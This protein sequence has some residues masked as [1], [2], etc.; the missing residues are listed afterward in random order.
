MI[1]IMFEDLYNMTYHFSDNSNC[2]H[3]LVSMRI[4][5]CL[6]IIGTYLVNLWIHFIKALSYESFKAFIHMTSNSSQDYQHLVS[7]YDVGKIKQAC[8]LPESALLLYQKCKD[9]QNSCFL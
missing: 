4:K 7:K 1:T 5:E 3:L 6:R 9:F 8:V 2:I